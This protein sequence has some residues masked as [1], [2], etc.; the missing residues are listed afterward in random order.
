MIGSQRQRFIEYELTLWG[1]PY[2]HGAQTREEGFDCSGM[3]MRGLWEMGWEIP[4][5]S[6]AGLWKRFIGRRVLYPHEGC[7]IFWGTDT[8]INHV[9]I[10]LGE[11]AG[12][13]IVCLGARK[14]KGKVVETVGIKRGDLKLWGYIDLFQSQT[15]PL[16]DDVPRTIAI[17]G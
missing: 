11:N 17:N 7:L 14:S 16:H 13:D 1:Y 15:V 6:A 8:A 9:E 2:V 5:H 3:V 4:D 10:S 12:G